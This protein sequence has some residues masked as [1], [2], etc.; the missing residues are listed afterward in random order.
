[1]GDL[2]FILV[3]LV[4]TLLAKLFWLPSKNPSDVLPDD[5]PLTLI[6]NIALDKASEV[7]QVDVKG[8]I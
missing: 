2:L 8:E 7:T 5:E 1:M 4:E 3:S 6:L